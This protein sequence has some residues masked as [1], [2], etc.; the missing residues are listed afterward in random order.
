MLIRCFILLAAFLSAPA[1][2]TRIT[3]PLVL[4]QVAPCLIP[5]EWRYGARGQVHRT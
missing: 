4:V 5:I 2:A 1:L 3:R